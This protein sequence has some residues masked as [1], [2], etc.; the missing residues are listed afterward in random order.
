MPEEIID[1]QP[2]KQESEAGRA[3]F[4]VISSTIETIDCLELDVKGNRRSLFKW[5][6]NGQLETSWLTP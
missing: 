3:N 6:E 5:N 4:A 1:R 2:T